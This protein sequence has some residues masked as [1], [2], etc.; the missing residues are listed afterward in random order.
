MTIANPPIF[1]NNLLQGLVT[2]Q[3]KRIIISHVFSLQPL[4]PRFEQFCKYADT[5]LCQSYDLLLIFIHLTSF[6]P[7]SFLLF[8]TT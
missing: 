6:L 4:G 8:K 5:T 1:Y 7:K 2:L 3:D